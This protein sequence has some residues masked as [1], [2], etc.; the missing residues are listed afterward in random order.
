MFG[1]RMSYLLRS[2]TVK[3]RVS[4]SAQMNAI[5]KL[6]ER[7]HLI[8]MYLVSSRLKINSKQCMDITAGGETCVS[9]TKNVIPLLLLNVS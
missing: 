2:H 9:T 4:R 1:G 6:Q 3:C 5:L 8:E 7:Q